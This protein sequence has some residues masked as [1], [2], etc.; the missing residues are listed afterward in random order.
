LRP[1]GDEQ[2]NNKLNL[3]NITSVGLWV[4]LAL[5]ALCWVKVIPLLFGWIGFGIAVPSF[6]VETINK[7]NMPPSKS[8]D[9]SG[10]TS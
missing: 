6:I 8:D 5:I 7:K 2:E 1:A 10:E 4:G 3:D 9:N